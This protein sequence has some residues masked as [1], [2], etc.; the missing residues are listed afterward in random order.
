LFQALE[1]LKELADVER[2]EWAKAQQQSQTA[3]TSTPSTSAGQASS[4]GSLRKAKPPP[5]LDGHQTERYLKRWIEVFRE[6]SF[7]I[8]TM[9]RAVFPPSS[10]ISLP[11]AAYLP[12]STPRTPLSPPLSYVSPPVSLLPVPGGGEEVER[13][14]RLGTITSRMPDER[15]SPSPLVTFTPHLIS[16]LT[17]TLR[18]YLPVVSDKSSRES[19]LTQVLYAAGSLGRL[20][21]DF[22]MILSTGVLGSL[23][24]V[25]EDGGSATGDG[26]GDGA[27]PEGGEWIEIMNKHKI[28]AGRLEELAQG[29]GIRSP[30]SSPVL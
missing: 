19:L 13:E 6:Q 25:V 14:S 28:L 18:N 16:I 11:S 15:T 1:P 29:R 4:T 30:G 9:Y 26:G 12:P 22:G 7:A 20:G 3:S 10:S 2:E 23:G 8:V 21:G 24:E 27:N 5:S 17:S